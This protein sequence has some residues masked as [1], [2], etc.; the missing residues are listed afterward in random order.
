[1]DNHVLVP[2]SKSSNDP[3]RRLR[4]TSWLSIYR[5]WLGPILTL[6][7]VLREPP[8]HRSNDPTHTH[9]CGPTVVY[10]DG[11]GVPHSHRFPC[12]TGIHSEPPIVRCE[13]G[14][15]LRHPNK[16][17]HP[18]DIRFLEPTVVFLNVHVPRHVGISM[19]SSGDPSLDTIVAH[20]SVRSLRPSHRFVV[21]V[22]HCYRDKIVTRAND[23]TVP[24]G[25]A[26]SCPKDNHG[27]VP[28]E[29]CQCHPDVRRRHM[30]AHPS[31]NCSP[32]PNEE[33]PHAPAPQRDD[34]YW[35]PKGSR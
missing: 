13:D 9:Y 17:S 1:M 14:Q 29:S 5:N 6:R 30:F 15:L 11:R 7:N 31:D 35:S 21:R 2:T 23:R 34:T 26:C 19:K 3:P 20:V 32:R 10:S 33:P 12:P 22:D 16:Y 18:M 25:R 24:P 4:N 28:N 8:W 27:I